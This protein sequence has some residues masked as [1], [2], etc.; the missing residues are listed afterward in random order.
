MTERPAVGVLRSGAH[1]QST[2]ALTQ[3]LRERLPDCEVVRAATPSAERELLSDTSVV[4]GHWFREALLDHAEGLRLFACA[5]AGVGHLPLEELQAR[6]VAVTNASGVHGPPIAEQVIGNILVF[7]RNLHIGWERGRKGEWR[8][9][10]G[11]QK[12][13]GD[14]TVT[15]VGLGAIGQAIVE[16][17][18]PFGPHTIGVRYTP[19][20]GGSTDEVVGFTETDFHDALARTDYL[21]L[22]CPLTETTR[23]LVDR[24]A[25]ETLPPKSVIVNIGRGPT[26]DTDALTNAV[27]RNAIRGAALDVTDPEPLPADHDLWAFPNV[28]ITPHN[29]GYTP[30]YYARVADIV[31]RN[32]DHVVE[33]GEYSGL[34]NQVV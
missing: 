24:A 21:V 6:G 19:S 7:V 26:V 4:V 1:G 2:D 12:E 14:S 31:A 34:K 27:Q 11:F 13:L 29:A 10:Q 30:N 9:Y 5:A 18:E 32:V 22:A 20:K 17:L 25:F 28:H 15:V 3:Q 8:H 23:G 16:R 33:T